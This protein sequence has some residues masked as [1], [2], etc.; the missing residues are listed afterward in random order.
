[1]GNGMTK[2]KLPNDI[3]EIKDWPFMTSQQEA[4]TARKLGWTVEE[5]R[6]RMIEASKPVQPLH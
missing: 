2:P 4:E 1:M 6:L 3:V 5:F